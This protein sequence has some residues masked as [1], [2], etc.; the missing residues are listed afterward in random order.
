M[1]MSRDKA[2]AAGDCVLG[3]RVVGAGEGDV[4]IGHGSTG[5]LAGRGAGRA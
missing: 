2:G 1:A 5:T 3:A 4:L